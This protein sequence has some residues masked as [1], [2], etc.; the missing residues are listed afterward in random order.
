MTSSFAPVT[1][2]KHNIESRSEGDAFGQSSPVHQLVSVI[3]AGAA[4]ILYFLGYIHGLW[5]CLVLLA[6]LFWFVFPGHGLVYGPHLWLLL[7][8]DLLKAIFITDRRDV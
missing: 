2:T 1:S 3:G 5:L 6:G 8:G 4:F 7:I